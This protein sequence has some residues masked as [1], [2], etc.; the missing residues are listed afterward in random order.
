MNTTS[1]PFGFIGANGYLYISLGGKKFL[2]HRLIMEISIRRR[3]SQDEFVHHI[4]G[5]KLDNRIENL[6]IMDGGK[7]TAFHLKERWNGR[8]IVTK[9]CNLCGSIFHRKENDRAFPKRKRCYECAKKNHSKKP[10]DHYFSLTHG[11]KSKKN[12]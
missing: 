6:K 7:H 4:N 2:A 3:L 1:R 12:G 5:N 9:T 11:K 8:K 10:F